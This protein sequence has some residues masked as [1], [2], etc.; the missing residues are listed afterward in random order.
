MVK[1]TSVKKNFIYNTIY[2]LL[3]LVIPFITTP[4]ISRILGPDGV[5]AYSYT[6][7]IAY[8]FVLF[9]ML[10]MTKY[11]NRT[12]AEVRENQEKL[13]QTFAE[14]YAMQLMTGVFSTLVYVL[15]IVFVFKNY[16]T[17]FIIQLIYV[18]SATFDISWFFFGIEEFKTT[19]V[20]NIVI[21]ILNVV[22]LLAFVKTENDVAVYCLIMAISNFFS[23]ISLWPILLKKYIRLQ[24]PH[25]AA[26]VG[27]FKTNIILFIPTI[28]VSVYKIM[29]KVMIGQ[30]INTIEV[31]YYENA[32]KIINIPM[33]LV[34]TMGTVMLPRMS[35]VIA[36]GNKKEEHRYLDIT[37]SFMLWIAC[38]M[39]CGIIAIADIFVP[40]FLGEDFKASTMI[41][42][43]LAPTMVFISWGNTIS[44][45]ILIPRKKD[46]AY[47]IIVGLGAIINLSLNLLLIP[48]I[49]ANGAALAT[50]ITELVV[51]LG[52]S[53]AGR[54]YLEIEKC[55]LRLIIYGVTGVTMVLV[56]R[57]LSVSFGSSVIDI[58]IK[59][60]IGAVYYCVVS[61][62]MT[63]LFNRPFYIFINDQ[64]RKIM[65]RFSRGRL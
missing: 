17:L 59:I 55:F 33:M 58:L 7:S 25:V 9:T 14:I 11:G 57:V 4:Y 46:I 28:A 39:S 22:C 53:V 13:N 10:G 50:L 54:K 65:P 16:Q 44:S 35:Y 32:E 40:L 38:A 5:G 12:I 27:H 15:C 1:K 29:D 6:F 18:L 19:V 30:L 36:T 26:I 37:M 47:I 23:Q 31:G 56:L 43:S 61:Y 41:V 63:Y 21:R 51:M 2:N 3:A 64:F 52:Y 62:L 24:K 20:R 60:I 49:H 8:Y 34:T 42:Y 45:Q 48:K